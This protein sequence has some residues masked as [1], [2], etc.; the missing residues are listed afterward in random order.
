MILRIDRLQ[1]ELPPPSDPDPPAARPRSSRTPTSR[2]LTIHKHE[3]DGTVPV[4]R[5]TGRLTGSWSTT[6]R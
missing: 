6:R 1:T 4:P 3:L 5:R 2:L